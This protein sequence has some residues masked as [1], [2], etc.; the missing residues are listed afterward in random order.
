MKQI[1]LRCVTKG[2]H[3]TLWIL[4]ISDDQTL[5]LTT[6]EGMVFGPLDK[7]AASASIRL[8][9]F[10]GNV[11]SLQIAVASQLLEFHCA[12]ADL[13]TIR[14][15]LEGS[16]VSIGGADAVA[17][18]RHSGKVAAWQGA[19]LMAL[20]ILVSLVSHQSA[21]ANGEGSVIFVG[22]ILFGL[23]RMALGLQSMAR[24]TRMNARSDA[25]GFPVLPPKD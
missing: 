13:F 15:Y 17:S 14:D 22:V 19:G 1:E 23:A 11:K 18:I 2:L 5:T 9:S 6:P 8:P 20:G 12:Q 4:R 25:P 21:R 16:V 7:V 3:W 10:W 24:A